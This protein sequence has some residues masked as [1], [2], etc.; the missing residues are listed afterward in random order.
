MNWS[1]TV[2]LC[3]KKK[4]LPATLKPSYL[5][6]HLHCILIACKLITNTSNS[7]LDFGQI[8]KN[9]LLLLMHLVES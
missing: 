2:C 3:Q 1:E 6:L 8:C 7:Q 5:H 4:S 9:A